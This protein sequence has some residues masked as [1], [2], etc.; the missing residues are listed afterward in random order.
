MKTSK[1]AMTALL[2]GMAW[3]LGSPAPAAAERG[4]GRRSG[5]QPPA[6]PDSTQIAQLVGDMAESISLT[7]EQ[8]AK[9]LA[10]HLAHNSDVGNLVASARG[11]K[12]P[13]REKMTELREEL[14]KDVKALLNERQWADYE[15]FMKSRRPEPRQSG[16]A[17]GRRRRR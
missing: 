10:L 1:L 11:E 12:R 9:V 7:P 16:E 4:M 14:E 6:R 17:T 13:D 8:E 3:S 2:L 15:A 5:G